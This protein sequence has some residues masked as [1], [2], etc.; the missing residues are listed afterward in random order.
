MRDS[1][2]YLGLVVD[3]QGLH[4]SPEKTIAVLN[5]PQPRNVKELRSLL[6]MMENSFRIWLAFDLSLTK[7]LSLVL[8]G[9][10]G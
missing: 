1:V 9:K 4:A 2:D 6:G 8:E 7:E 3:E 5:A 10:T